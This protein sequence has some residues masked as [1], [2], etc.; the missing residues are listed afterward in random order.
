MVS[1]PR[2]DYET[3]TVT[4]AGRKISTT[5]QRRVFNNNTIVDP[6]KPYRKSG[7]M[8]NPLFAALP[9]LPGTLR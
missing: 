6:T 1:S 9:T 5:Y 3:V 7:G 2:E 8:G 4:K